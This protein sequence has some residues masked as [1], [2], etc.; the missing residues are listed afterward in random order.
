MEAHAPA[1]YDKD[2]LMAIRA[3]FSGTASPGQQQMAMDWITIEACRSR[4][5]TFAGEAT[6][7]AAFADGRRF[8]AMQIAGM[9][10]PKALLFTEEAKALKR[11]AQ[12][13]RS[14]GKR[15]EATE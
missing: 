4:Y 3:L 6:H 9:L 7:T 13:R 12:N 1:P 14:R 11:A 8:V 2:I 5:L 10:E 15:Q